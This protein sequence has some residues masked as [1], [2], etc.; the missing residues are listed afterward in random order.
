MVDS[1][2]GRS[3]A[4]DSIIHGAKNTLGVDVPSRGKI[5]DDLKAK[6]DQLSMLRTT[7]VESLLA[8]Y[9][10]S[11]EKRIA[12][13]EG[14]IEALRR[15]NEMLKQQHQKYQDSVSESAN[16]PASTGRTSDVSTLSRADDTGSSK[17]I[18]CSP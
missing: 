8:E 7:A 5:I 11:A 3:P 10:A 4:K 2:K 14:L 15:E 9:K 12:A 6:F 16:R 17:R 1:K 18:L 13:S